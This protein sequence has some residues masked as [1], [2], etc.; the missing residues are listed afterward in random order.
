MNLWYGRKSCG[1]YTFSQIELKR[2]QNKES[3]Y[4][5]FVCEDI[6]DNIQREY[7]QG[8][9]FHVLVKE[10]LWLVSGEGPYEYKKDILSHL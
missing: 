3:K 7:I 4:V 10:A 6:I 2:K 8:H 5:Y 1:E 9:F